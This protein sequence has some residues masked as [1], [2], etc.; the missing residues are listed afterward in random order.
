VG[1]ARAPPP[2]PPPPP[3]LPGARARTARSERGALRRTRPGP[4]YLA[5]VAVIWT[6]VIKLG[7]CVAAQARARAKRVPGTA[8]SWELGCHSRDNVFVGRG[9]F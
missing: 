1:P 6:E 5:S 8:G 9:L 4:Q 2:P 3:P 7:V